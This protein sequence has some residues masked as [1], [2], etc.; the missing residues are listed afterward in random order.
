MDPL[1]MGMI[2]GG[3]NLL[4][5]I[6][7]SDTSAK[8]TEEQIAAQQAMQQQSQKFNADQAQLNRDFQQQMSNTAYQRASSDMQRAGLNPMMMFGSGGA[9]S[10]PGGAQ[11]S[12]G[13]PSVPMSQKTS[14]MAGLGA[15]VNAAVNTAISTKTFD[16][17]TE[18]IANVR[19]DTAKREAEVLTEKERPEQVRQSTLLTADQAATIANRMPVARLEGT[20]AKDILDMPA[21]LRTA[22]VQ[23][24]F[25]ADKSGKVTDLIGSAAGSALGIKRLFPQRSTVER[26]DSSGG[27]TFEERF[28][29]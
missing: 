7:S 26:S 6:F 8:N 19:A 20:T 9:A 21:W 28:H 22:L 16:K 14:P 2:S 10:S 13:T 11:A 1:T 29:Y 15:A 17:M 18:E 4:G 25:T 23:A 27:S 5:S 12:T 3:M 24:G